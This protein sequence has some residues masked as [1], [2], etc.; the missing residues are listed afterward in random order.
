MILLAFLWAIVLW[1]LFVVAGDRNSFILQCIQ[2]Q[3]LERER[4]TTPLYYLI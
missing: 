2:Q 1:A 4:E 3:Q